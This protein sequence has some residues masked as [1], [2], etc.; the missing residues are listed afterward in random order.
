MKNRL[1]LVLALLVFAS[2]ACGFFSGGGGSDSVEIEAPSAPSGGGEPGEAPPANSGSGETTEFPLPPHV[3]N[4]MEMG[5]D[6]I[7]YQ[8][9]MAL[10]DVVE[11]YQGEFESQGYTERTILTV[12]SDDNT[13]FNLVFDGHPSGKAI[14]IQGVDL[15]N[16]AVNVNVRLEDV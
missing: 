15:G 12:I 11:F 13:T 7:N 9:D 10:L 14:V 5:A 2:M 3:E 16:G 6:A 1:I 4:F 8:T